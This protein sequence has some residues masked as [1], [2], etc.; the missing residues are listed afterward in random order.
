MSYRPTMGGGLLK[1]TPGPGNAVA[2]LMGYTNYKVYGAAART[3][4]NS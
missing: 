2:G 3:K 4:S 1:G